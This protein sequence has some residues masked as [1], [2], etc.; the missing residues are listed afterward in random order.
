[1]VTKTTLERKGKEGWISD[2]FFQFITG[3][4]ATVIGSWCSD[5]SLLKS[6]Q[7][8]RMGSIGNANSSQLPIASV[9]RAATALA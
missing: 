2:T 8:L 5:E 1:M 9:H 6:M 7:E 3:V 4:F